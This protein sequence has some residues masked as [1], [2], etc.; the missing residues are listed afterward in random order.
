LP[1]GCAAVRAGMRG[2]QPKHSSPEDP[3]TAVPTRPAGGKKFALER[4]PSR[5]GTPLIFKLETGG[6]GTIARSEARY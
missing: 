2:R 5:N 3:P 6:A 1:H 4:A